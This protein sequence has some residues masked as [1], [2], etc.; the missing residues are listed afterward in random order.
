MPLLLPEKKRLRPSGSSMASDV[1]YWSESYAGAVGEL[2]ARLAL[3]RQ[4][5]D[6]DL[7]DFVRSVAVTCMS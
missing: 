6:N 4:V 5:S 7:E 1:D 2:A 3:A